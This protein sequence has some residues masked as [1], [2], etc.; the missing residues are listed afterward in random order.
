MIEEVSKEMVL[1]LMEEKG[2]NMREALQFLY[3][4]DTYARLTDTDNGLYAQ[5]VAYIYE[6]LEN[7]LIKGKIA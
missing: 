2:M 7:E 1:L 6:Y 5:S 4:S 3:T